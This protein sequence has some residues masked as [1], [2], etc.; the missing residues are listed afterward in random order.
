MSTTYR[1]CP[2]C[3]RAVPRNSR[4]R[5]CINDGEPLISRCPRCRAPIRNPY[6]RHCAG[7]G[8]GFATLLTAATAKE[9]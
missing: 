7:C 6:A 4:E 3:L 9:R 5:H 2:R 8:L 1:L